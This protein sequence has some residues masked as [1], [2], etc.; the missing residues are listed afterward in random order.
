MKCRKPNCNNEVH[1]FDNL[2][3]IVH[4]QERLQQKADKFK[5]NAE[6]PKIEQKALLHEDFAL[7]AGDISVTSQGDK[8][9][10][11]KRE[12]KVYNKICEV[13][14]DQAFALAI[15]IK[16]VAACVKHSKG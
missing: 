3:C 2:I 4:E 14:I 12:G 5:A 6:S 1:N 9:V 13:D 11:V 16:A 15:A 10:L 7:A 8:I